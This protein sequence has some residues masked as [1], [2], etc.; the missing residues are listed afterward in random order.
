MSRGSFLQ[1]GARAI[2]FTISIVA[3]LIVMMSARPAWSAAIPSVR[4]VP[5]GEKLPLDS[6]VKTTAPIR[7]GRAPT[8]QFTAAVGMFLKAKEDMGGGYKH[9]ASKSPAIR[10]GFQTV[11][12]KNDFSV[13]FGVE[14][15]ASRM[16]SEVSSSLASSSYTADRADL[17]P[18]IGLDW[19]P[20]GAGTAFQLQGIYG[21]GLNLDRTRTIRSPGFTATLPQNAGTT[22]FGNLIDWISLQGIYA[23]TPNVRLI[24][25]VLIVDQSPALSFGV[26]YAY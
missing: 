17:G 8:W 22:M 3:A 10:L 9:V 2:A 16:V 15:I 4:S 13:F 19:Y 11:H 6:S 18:T 5:P 20:N 24:G 23:T 1:T 7:M 12:P 14:L 21:I 26:G 25:G